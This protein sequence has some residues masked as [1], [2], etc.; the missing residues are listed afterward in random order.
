VALWVCDDCGSRFAVG[1]RMCPQCTSEQAH[2]EGDDDMPKTT[3]YGGATNA[4][5]DDEQQTEASADVEETAGTYAGWSKAELVTECDERGLPKTGNI[6]DLV[7]RL[8]A[9]DATPA[10]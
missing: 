2:E 8:E 6:P 9:D 10:E 3:V 5:A 4:A 7:A 1:L